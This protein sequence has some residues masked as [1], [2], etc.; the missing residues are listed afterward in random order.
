[1][2]DFNKITIFNCKL[3]EI[4]NCQLNIQL[5]RRWVH[6]ELWSWYGGRENLFYI[7]ILYVLLYYSQ[8]CEKCSQPISSLRGHQGQNFFADTIIK[9]LIPTK[10]ICDKNCC[11]Q[12]FINKVVQIFT[13]QFDESVTKNVVKVLSILMKFS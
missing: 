2:D 10:S 9:I 8:T 13:F 7:Y 4:Y 3:Q 5:R 11:D 1:M 12:L 6:K